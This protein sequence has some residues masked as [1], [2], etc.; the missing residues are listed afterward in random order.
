MSRLNIERQKK[1]EPTRIE[2]AKKEI[3]ALGYE[4]TYESGTE[5]N[6]MYNGENV[7]FFPYSG[8]HSGRSIN[9]GRGLK[10]LLDQIK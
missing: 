3:Q 7:I 8:W 2:K 1:L 10:K 6:F 4:I 5:L 9:D